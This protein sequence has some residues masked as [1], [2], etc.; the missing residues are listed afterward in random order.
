[1]HRQIFSTV[2]TRRPVRGITCA[3]TLALSAGAVAIAGCAPQIQTQIVGQS[4]VIASGPS[5]L[6]ADIPVPESKS[7]QVLR[8][9][10]SLPRAVQLHYQ[11]TCPSV[12]REGTL[13]ETFD[14]YRTRRLAELERERQAQANLI[15]SVVGA[16]GPRVRAGAGVAGPGGSATVQA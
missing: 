14:K 4:T 3:I 10:V 13:G 5:A 12:E 16:M 7:P 2:V 9:V 11:V 15:G 1:M 8:Y 6:A